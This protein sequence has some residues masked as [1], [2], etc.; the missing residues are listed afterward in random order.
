M[1]HRLIAD[2][3][4]VQTVRAVT[5]ATYLGLVE[6]I[7]GAV[8]SKPAGFTL[9]RGP[10]AFSFCN[11]AA[12][13]D[14]ENSKDA[15][16]ALIEQSGE[17]AGFYVFVMTGDK[18]EDLSETLLAEGFE[19][20]QELTSM[21]WEPVECQAGPSL[22]RVTDQNDR[23]FVTKFMCEQFFARLPIEAREAIAAATAASRNQ[24]F[25]IGE[26]ETPQ[27]AVMLVPGSGSIGLY[28]LCV[29]PGLRGQ[30]IGKSVVESIKSGAAQN[31]IKVVLQC[32]RSLVP[33]YQGLG[34]QTVG[35]VRAYTFSGT[36]SGDILTS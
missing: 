15:V 20:R 18:P 32:D 12:E 13:F 17:C 2:R 21:V 4:T 30:G 19:L 31:G 7:N 28:N 22:D 14:A 1:E 34:F 27:A 11:F 23:S 3:E 5:V 24:I 9:V 33:W 8:I 26:S 29:R 25:K 16:A 36:Y 10:G 6:P 35:S